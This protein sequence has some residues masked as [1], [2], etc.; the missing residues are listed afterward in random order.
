MDVDGE[1]SFGLA[2]VASCGSLGYDFG[3]LGYG[4]VRRGLA[5]PERREHVQNA[6]AR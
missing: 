1:K 4:V 6:H 5:R 2:G 3:R